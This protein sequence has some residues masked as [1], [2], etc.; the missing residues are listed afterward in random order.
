[1]D[2]PADSDMIDSQRRFRIV[3]AC[4]GVPTNAGPLAAVNITEEFTRRPWR[5]DVTCTWD[6]Q[7]LILQAENDF[8]PDGLALIDE[9]SDAI[10]ACIHDGFDGD[11]RIAAVTELTG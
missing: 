3:L 10:S 1:M 11:I 4:D 6:G 2:S 9:F 5:Q 8:D 7:S